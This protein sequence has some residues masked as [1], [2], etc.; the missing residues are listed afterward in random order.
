MT[1]K[2][3]IRLENVLSGVLVG[4]LALAVVIYFGSTVAGPGGEI[5]PTNLVEWIGWVC[6]AFAAPAEWL[7][8]RLFH[9]ALSWA[10]LLLCWLE[11]VVVSW[12]LTQPAGC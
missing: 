8:E 1:A 3:Q 2:W 5:T 4:S 12:L 11:C 6:L 9:N 7:A 10:S